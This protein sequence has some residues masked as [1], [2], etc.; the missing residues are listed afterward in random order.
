MAIEAA[1]GRWRPGHA[2]ASA[3]STTEPT[4]KPEAKTELEPLQE[5]VDDEDEDEE[6]EEEGEEEESAY[7]P[8]TCHW[9]TCRQTFTGEDGPVDL[10]VSTRTVFTSPF[11]PDLFVRCRILLPDIDPVPEPP[12]RRPCR[13]R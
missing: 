10:V 1:I 11:F 3:S 13:S 4:P 5:Q 8:Q 7:E 9:G 6:E 12:Q 2:V